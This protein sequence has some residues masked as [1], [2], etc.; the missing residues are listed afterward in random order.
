MPIYSLT[1][2]Y[3]F[4]WIVKKLHLNKQRNNDLNYTNTKA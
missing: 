3:N 4:I 2:S 1:Y